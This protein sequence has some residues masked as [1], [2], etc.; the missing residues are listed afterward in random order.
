M[1]AL[2]LKF[3]AKTDIVTP[4]K[5]FLA[6]RY[7]VR[8][9]APRRPSVLFARARTCRR[10]RA[11]LARAPPARL[12]PPLQDD[13]SKH[14]DALTE[15]QALRND[16]ASIASASESSRE[17]LLKCV[18]GRGRCAALMDESDHFA[19]SLCCV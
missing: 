14:V 17:A 8:G 7:K 5:A 16:V 4:L 13:A 10:T 19:R 6:A 3:T 15:L 1:L 2:P 9:L 12:P 11:G 18:A